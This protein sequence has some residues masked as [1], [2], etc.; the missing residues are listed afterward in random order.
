MSYA[1]DP[2]TAFQQPTVV[3]FNQLWENDRSFHEGD[4]I[5]SGAIKPRHL[6]DELGSKNWNVQLTAYDRQA[7]VQD[8]VFWFNMP[9]VFDTMKFTN[10]ALRAATPGTGGTMTVQIRNVTK[11][12]NIFSSVLTLG[13]GA[14]LSTTFTINAA[15]EDV[16]AGDLILVNV[17]GVHTTP[18]KTVSLDIF[19]ER[20]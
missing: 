16:D 15:N 1:N 17:T 12:V 19:I 5:A 14:S 18:A 4:G 11:S 20:Q 7:R 13:D 6:G 9:A 2:F 3:E 10:F 8:G